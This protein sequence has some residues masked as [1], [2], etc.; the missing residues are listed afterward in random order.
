[1]EVPGEREQQQQQQQDA[2]VVDDAAQTVQELFATF[3]ATYRVPDAGSAATSQPY[4]VAE[5]R[6]MRASGRT[7][8]YVDW[9]HLTAHD[10]GL[11]ELVQGAYVRYEPA[12][13][14]AL[15]NVAARVYN[16]ESNGDGV[17]EDGEETTLWLGFYNLPRTERL[18][19]LRTRC[20]GTLVAL[21][22][23]VTRT[24][25]V[26]PELLRGTFRCLD[27]Q[28]EVRDVA[29]QFK[30]TE[31]RRCA[32]AVC[33]NTTRWDLDLERSVFVDWQKCHVQE[34]SWEIPSGAM[35]RTLDV[36]LRHEDVERAKAGDKCV[37][38]GTV[39]VIPDVSKL[40]ATAHGVS[41]YRTP[42]PNAGPGP[43]TEGVSGLRDLGAARLLSYRL[44]FLACCVQPL[45]NNSRKA[46]VHGIINDDDEEEEENGD[47][48]NG[49]GDDGDE[50]ED[51]NEDED[52]REERRRKRREE[53][54]RDRFNEEELKTVEE[55]R[56]EPELY[57][58]MVAS[59]A[60]NIYGHEDVKRGV[61]LLMFGGVHK[62]TREGI[63]L[64]GD[65]NVC[66]IGDPS[67]AKSQ[68]L[69]YVC[70][71]Y[72][73]A[74]FTS[75]K[76]STAAGLTASVV[77]DDDTGEF[78]I[79]AGALMLADNG[80]CCIDEFD[81]MDVANQVAIHET[82]EQQTISIAK[83]GIHAT[84]NARTSILAAANPVGGRYDRARPLRANFNIGAPL[85]SRFDLFFVVLDDCDPAV[86]RLVADHIV[87]VHQH[88]DD[89]VHPPFATA[90]LRTYLRYARALRPAIAPD[91]VPL[92]AH[93]YARLR[94]GDAVGTAR[95]SSFRITVRQLESLIRL[96]EAL[97]RLHLDPLVR[98][99]YVDEA[100]RLL[101]RSITR[102]DSRDVV[103]SDPIP[104]S[105]SDPH[106]P[107]P[108][109][110]QEGQEQQQGKTI[111]LPAER[112]AFMARALVLHMERSGEGDSS[113][114]M[115]VGALVQWYVSAHPEDCADG[116]TAEDLAHTVRLVVRHMVE[117]DNTLLVLSMPDPD[118]VPTP[119]TPDTFDALV[120]K[121]NPNY[122]P[123]DA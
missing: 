40:G 97:A 21:T 119:D 96:A 32:S 38:T 68:F 47:E 91:A 31:P 60:P 112:Y 70:S 115:Q 117:A 18:R 65:I 63:S 106:P 45:D 72:P 23:T 19:D 55:M 69:K 4:Y 84:L 5:L 79:E 29:Q 66:I 116:T 58:K 123:H 49:N 105:L 9:R 20:V 50:M 1:M 121:A 92:F 43:D 99:A 120:V 39:V 17:N 89:A 48:E 122:D 101:H 94:Q 11:A 78:S 86:D 108:G 98:P 41:T 81:K 53:M 34:N 74:V 102:V 26:R 67:T 71:F 82:M 57:R 107:D 33:A 51:D 61:L 14:R 16:S 10:A 111:S 118:A 76:A 6:A 24:S 62:R 110:Q 44:G 52:V 77:R 88:L 3:L 73:R 85:M 100:A 83:A 12:L 27:C 56:K 114:G 36:V 103:L 54:I 42:A 90:Q 28:T 80:I 30:F 59:V 87:A 46:A 95:A 113:G 104:P 25:E 2:R 35:P 75:G 22:A 8:L 109:Q 64:R 15:Q 13:R 37:F 93:H 7:T